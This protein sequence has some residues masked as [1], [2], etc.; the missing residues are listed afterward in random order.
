M[1]N[2]LLLSFYIG[3]RFALMNIKAVL[4]HM[5]KDF[6]F[7]ICEQTVLPLQMGRMSAMPAKGIHL[8][9]KAR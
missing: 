8:G 5:L 1:V 9:L 3:S 6:Q 4:Y 7:E 2:K